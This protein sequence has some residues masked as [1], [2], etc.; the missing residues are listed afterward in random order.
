[1][2]KITQDTNTRAET[3]LW[4]PSKTKMVAHVNVSISQYAN[5][6]LVASHARM[7]ANSGRYVFTRLSDP[8]NVYDCPHYLYQMLADAANEVLQDVHAADPHL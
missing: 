7:D 3:R 1:M 5:G 8:D 4:K 6:G 2:D